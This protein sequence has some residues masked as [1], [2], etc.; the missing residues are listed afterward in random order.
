MREIDDVTVGHFTNL[1]TI[2]WSSTKF[3][4]QFIHKIWTIWK[5]I[6]NFASIHT[7]LWTWSHTRTLKLVLGTVFL[8]TFV[9]KYLIDFFYKAKIRSFVIKK[10]KC[11]ISLNYVQILNLKNSVYMNKI[12]WITHRLNAVLRT[13]R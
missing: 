1:V 8:S 11:F 2:C 7:V 13:C 9:T 12:K 5:T 10:E 3:T 6:T 4:T